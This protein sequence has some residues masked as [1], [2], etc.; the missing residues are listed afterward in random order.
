MITSL[1][2]FKFRRG[3]E[4]NRKTITPEEGE[5]IFSM[6]AKRLSIGDGTTNGGIPINKTWISEPT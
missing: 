3:E 4:K 2:R 1:C 5:P 6:D